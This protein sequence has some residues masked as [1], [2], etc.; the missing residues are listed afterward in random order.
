MIEKIISFFTGGLPSEIAK[1]IG[2]N[3]KAKGEAAIQTFM[4]EVAFDLELLKAGTGDPLHTRQVIA[5]T[6]HFFMWGKL[7]FTGHFP[8][9]I[10][11]TWGDKAVTIGLA[12]CLIITFYFPARALEKFKKVF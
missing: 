6:F 1:Q 10:I 12:Y 11:F 9:D 8:A 4:T 3:I 5:L 2:E 7:F